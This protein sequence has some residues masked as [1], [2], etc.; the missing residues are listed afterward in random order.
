ALGRIGSE[1]RAAVPALRKAIHSGDPNM[2][3]DV[4]LALANIGEGAEEAIPVLLDVLSERGH[5]LRLRAMEALSRI[6]GTSEA[7]VPALVSVL[8]EEDPARPK[9]AEVLG[10]LGPAATEALPALTA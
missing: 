7:L 2:R 4:A 1:A 10:R 9:A 3:L 6:P 5:S 8:H